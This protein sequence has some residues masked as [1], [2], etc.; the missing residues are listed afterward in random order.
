MTD[1]NEGILRLQSSGRWAICRPG[2]PPFEITSGDRFRIEV[3]GKLKVTRMEF[4]HFTGTMKAQELFGRAGEYYS[5]D[6]YCLRD[7]A[8][9]G[10]G[11]E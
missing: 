10:I 9:A 6:G 11:A 3:D 4:R 2:A 7:G 8:R 1:K 5:A